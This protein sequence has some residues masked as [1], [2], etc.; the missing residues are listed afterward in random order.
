MKSAEAASFGYSSM[1]GGG[2]NI[3]HFKVAVPSAA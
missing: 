2:D 1:Q 3:T